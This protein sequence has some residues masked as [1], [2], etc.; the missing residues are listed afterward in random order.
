MATGIGTFAL[1]RKMEKVIPKSVLEKVAKS[2]EDIDSR[3][4]KVPVFTRA[5]ASNKEDPEKLIK[6]KSSTLEADG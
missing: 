2:I 6:R 1:Y 3:K 5:D 4:I